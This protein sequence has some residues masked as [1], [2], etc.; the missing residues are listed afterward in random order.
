MDRDEK[1][2]ELAAN[3]TLYNMFLTEAIFELLAERGILTGEEVKAR[4][5]K[6]RNEVPAQLRWMQ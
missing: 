5:E 1:K 4:V 3:V 6:L 2:G